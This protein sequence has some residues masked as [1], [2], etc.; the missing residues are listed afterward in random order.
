M[1]NSKSIEEI[2]SSMSVPQALR[3]MAVPTVISQ[4]IVLIYNMADTFYIGQTNDP[5]MVAGV[6]LMLPAFNLAVAFGT[7]FGLGGGALLPRLLAVGDRD[8][9]GKTAA[10]C[11][12]MGTAV[13][14]T[15]SLLMLLFMKPLLLLLGANENTLPHARTYALLVMVLGGLPS[16]LS[17]ILSNIL[18]SLGLSREAGVGVALGGVLNIFLDPLFMYV[19]LPPGNEVLGVALATLISCVISCLYC[20]SC[21]FRRQK[22]INTKLFAP[23][24]AKRNRRAVVTIGASGALGMILFDLDY[25]FL[26][27]LMSAYGETALAAI[28]IVLKVERLPQQIGVGLCQGMVPLVAYSHALKDYDRTKKIMGCTLKTGGIVAL[29][30]VILYELF[31]PFI[32]AFFI[33]DP[34]TLATG[35]VFLRI[36]TPAAV[37]MFFC[38]FAV[39]L[40]QGLGNGRRSS[41]LASVRW[42]GINIPML[43]ILDACFG[44]LGLAWAQFI[45]DFIMTLISFVVV[46]RI[47]RSW[48]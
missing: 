27:R 46:Y 1:K 44:M 14:I 6:S 40:S 2:Y 26:G 24:P 39:F 29:V 22:L 47:A 45:S 3:A 11:L 37:I 17:N 36:R 18:R 15:A 16:V 10:Y 7:L 28:G 20:L 25:L 8:E 48:K 9:A 12:R 31:A 13:A 5:Y 33:D 19:L 34:A 38:F 35:T 42:L 30:S 21:F 43:F 41:V 4:L 23:T 32:M